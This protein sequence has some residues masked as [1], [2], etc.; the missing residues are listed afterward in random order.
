VR[1]KTA[2][3][4]IEQLGLKS[5]PEG[6]Y[7]AETYRSAEL[8]GGGALP[9]RYAGSRPFSTAIYFLLDAGSISALHRIASDE[10]WHFYTGDPL[11]VEAIH[12]EGGLQSFLLGGDDELGCVF[13]AVVPAGCWFGAALEPPVKPEG[14]ALVGCTVAPGF[15]FA[16]FELGDRT[17]LLERYPEHQATIERLTRS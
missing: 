2:E 3:F 4:W 11:R 14:Y 16:D 10:V 9:P 13:Q 7:F 5:H 8:V 17:D 15:D 6:G 12:P 1:R